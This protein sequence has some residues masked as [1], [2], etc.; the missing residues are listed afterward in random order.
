MIRGRSNCGAFLFW[1]NRAGD[2][3]SLASRA[4]DASTGI[5]LK[6]HIFTAEVPR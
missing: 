5:P 2:R 1:H 3:M 4:L 6:N